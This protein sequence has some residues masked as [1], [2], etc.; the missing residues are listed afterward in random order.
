MGKPEF[1]GKSQRQTVAGS[2]SLD[3]GQGS[4]HPITPIPPEQPHSL[5]SGLS[6]WCWGW[7][8]GEPSVRLPKETGALVPSL[9]TSALL[10]GVCGQSTQ[11]SGLFLNLSK[12]RGSLG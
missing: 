9:P 4:S 8:P 2:G 6:A 1:R 7:A 10:M 3:P 12:I 5:W 11:P